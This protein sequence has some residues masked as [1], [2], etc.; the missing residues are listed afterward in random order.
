MP[1]RKKE[2]KRNEKSLKSGAFVFGDNN[3]VAVER[4]KKWA[5]YD[6]NGKL[7]I[8]GYNRRICQEYADAQTK[9]RL[10]RQRKNRSRRT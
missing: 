6:K 7:I 4:G 8:L 5:V 9:I 10:K 1:R 3:P 2:S